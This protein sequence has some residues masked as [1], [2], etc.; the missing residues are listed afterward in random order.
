MNMAANERMGADEA[1]YRRYLSGDEAGAEQLVRKYGDALKSY[2]NGFIHDSH[3][4]E[5][6]MIEAFALLFAKERAICGDGAFRA[7]LYKTARNL[8]IRH[9][10]RRFPLFSMD[11]LPFEPHSDA[12]ADAEL[13]RS[14]RLRGLERAMNGLKAE[15]REALYLVYFEEMSYRE[16]AA[17]L[18]KSERQLT[19]LVFRGKASLK[20][21]LDREGFCYEGE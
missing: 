16:A 21:I 1:A 18:E 3:E 17:V 13:M 10:K 4:S 6:L 15:Y 2:I 9:G 5:D 8:T 20:A 19:N 14:E 7:Y 12:R 11:E